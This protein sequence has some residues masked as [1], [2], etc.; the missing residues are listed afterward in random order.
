MELL[1]YGLHERASQFSLE[2]Q[3]AGF[4]V[5]NDAVFNQ[6]LVACEND[7]ITSRT[8]ELIQQS[9]ECWCGSAQW[10][11]RKVIRI[12]VSSWATTSEDISRSVKAFEESYERIKH[13]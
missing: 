5:L 6:V 2:I 7:D 3:K 8:L 13:S 1:D 10:D 4:Q 11:N 9:G 12:S